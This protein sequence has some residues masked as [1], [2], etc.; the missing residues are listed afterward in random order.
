MLNCDNFE[1]VEKECI[2]L[3]ATP[4]LAPMLHEKLQYP[5][6][7]LSRYY[8]LY[9]EYSSEHLP[10]ICY[11]VIFNQMSFLAI[12]V[13]REVDQLSEKMEKIF[14]KILRAQKKNDTLQW[15]NAVL[16]SEN[17]RFIIQTVENHLSTHYLEMFDLWKLYIDYLKTK[18]ME[19]SPQKNTDSVI[20]HCIF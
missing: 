19:V 17:E 18:D 5:H 10:K 20:R 13:P 11:L 2:E 16:E 15:F 7:L 9:Q 12:P 1:E 4:K 3:I 14:I 6:N 8:A